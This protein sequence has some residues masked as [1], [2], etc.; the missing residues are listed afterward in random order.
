[1]SS[2]LLPV[3]I[4]IKYHFP[5]GFYPHSYNYSCVELHREDADTGAKKITSRRE[6]QTVTA[7]LVA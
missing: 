5:D 4:K 3:G 7:F 6:E 1:M 2:K